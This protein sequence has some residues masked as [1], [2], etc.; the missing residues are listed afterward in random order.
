MDYG[1]HASRFDVLEKKS[2]QKWSALLNFMMHLSK[3]KENAFGQQQKQASFLL[4][5]GHCH[6][7]DPGDFSSY[8]DLYS[9]LILLVKQLYFYKLAKLFC[10][11]AKWHSA[12]F[13]SHL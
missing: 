3:V 1:V 4:F 11:N 7:T 10:K 6:F 2:S 13:F 8:V 9:S 12:N 5:L